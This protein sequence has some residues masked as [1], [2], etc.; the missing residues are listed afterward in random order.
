MKTMQWYLDKYGESHQNKTN[1]TIHWI[2]VPIIVFTLA[3]MLFSVPFP[4]SAEKNALFN[5][6]APIFIV[7]LLF[8]VTKS[9]PIFIGMFIYSALVLLGNQWLY[10]ALGQSNGKLALVSFGIFALAWVF[11]FKGHQIEGK[12]PSFLEDM[13]FLLIGPAWLLHFIYKKL[14]INY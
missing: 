5:W 13:K 7:A 14:N 10:E 8:Y 12:K 3:G 11:Q 2:C 4:F 1:K 9:I 6:T